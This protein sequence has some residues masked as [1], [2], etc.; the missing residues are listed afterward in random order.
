MEPSLPLAVGPVRYAR[1]QPESTLLYQL[2]ERHYPDF[3]AVLARRDR[4]LPL[5]VE[6]EFEAYLKCC[7][8][9]RSGSGCS[10]YRLRCVSSLPP[11]R[12]RWGRCSPSTTGPSRAT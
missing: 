1:H 11:S 10:P 12:R 3:L 7:R 6:K 4:C 9:S 5:Y 2:V 8:G